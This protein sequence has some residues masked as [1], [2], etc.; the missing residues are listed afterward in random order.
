MSLVQ[1]KY[2][3]LE[4]RMFLRTILVA[5]ITIVFYI[6]YDMLAG[7]FGE[8]ILSGLVGLFVFLACL[9][10]TLKHRDIKQVVFINSIVFIGS[11]SATFFS[12]NGMRGVFPLDLLNLYLFVGLITSGST[13]AISIGLCILVTVV[14]FYIQSDRSD[15]IFDVREG[16]PILVTF[17][18]MFLRFLLTLSL[19]LTVK[20]EYEKEKRII[21]I[22][23]RDLTTKNKE[24]QRINNELEFSVKSRTNEILS[25]NQK[26]IDFAF[27]DSENIKGELARLLGL[28]YVLKLIKPEDKEWDSYKEKLVK[29]SIDFDIMIDKIDLIL[30]DGLAQSK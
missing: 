5:L 27:Y 8:K 26:M 10:F 21:S 9:I 24:I 12:M 18:F 4:R 28:V 6:V 29:S 19:G 20:E 30:K 25:Q 1:S 15:L 2:Q 7:N 22:L 16:D 14:F 11:I 13:K 17:F 23:N 3:E